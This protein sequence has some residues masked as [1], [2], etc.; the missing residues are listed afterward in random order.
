L[1]YQ[2]GT[3]FAGQRGIGTLDEI[4]TRARAE[5]ETVLQIG[6]AIVQTLPIKKN[7]K[8]FAEQMVVL[9]DS[10]QRF[11]VFNGIVF[12]VRAIQA[13]RKLVIRGF[14]AGLE[15]RGGQ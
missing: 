9:S 8:S 2:A 10:V 6:D 5:C 3:D 14:L 4:I 13:E 11:N 12:T 15:S 1:E 7:V